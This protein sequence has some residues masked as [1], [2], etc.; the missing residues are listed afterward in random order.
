MGVSGIL[1]PK[2]TTYREQDSRYT[3]K[4]GH[5]PL[6]GGNGKSRVCFNP[7]HLRV[8]CF[9]NLVPETDY[10]SGTRFPIHRQKWT[11][12]TMRRGN[13]NSKQPPGMSPSSLGVSGILFPKL[14]TY[15]EQDSRYTG[16]NGHSPLCGGNDNS[17]QPPGMSP[18]SLGVSGILFPK[19]TTY[20]E[21]DSRY[22]GK[23]G[24]SP[25]CGGN[26]KSRVCFNPR[27]LRVGCFGN[28][29]PETDYVSGTRF[30]IHREKWTLTIMRRERQLE[31]APWHES[32]EWVFR[33][34][35]SRN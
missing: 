32:F 16:K 26:D 6:C 5:S 9:G 3:G 13:D 12:T 20:R 27:H 15:R 22:T 8:G 29:V 25:L 14:T 4:N 10:V 21:Q 24:H 33:E 18:S 30:P 23:N 2:L 7:R 1:F 17:K 19:L 28:L 34:S 31:A 11:L 35:C